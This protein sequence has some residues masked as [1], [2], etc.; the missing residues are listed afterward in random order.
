MQG[1]R[2][3][4]FAGLVAMCLCA[5]ACAD[6]DPGVTA[7]ESAS[8]PFTVGAAPGDGAS[9]EPVPTDTAPLDTSTADT[10]TADTDGAE[11]YDTVPP[12]S[13]TPDTEPE[14]GAP[15]GPRT[16]PD[17]IG[18]RLFPELGNPGVDVVDMHVVLTY[19]LAEDALA[20][21]VT[22]TID[23]TEDRD[24]FTLDSAGPV[25][26]AVTVDGTAA[27]FEQDDD[28]LRIT[29]DGGIT[30]GSHIR[31]FAHWTFLSRRTKRSY[32]GQGIR[33]PTSSCMCL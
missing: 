5:A 32:M 14:P 3:R 1:V 9:Q 13:V 27:A 28:E 23:P 30:T 7:V 26:S 11:S 6:T 19:D 16:D 15:N 12:D 29:P 33:S 8:T 10:S 22:L 25:V 18:D 17:G 2:G 24:E 4:A 21:S 20:G 31:L